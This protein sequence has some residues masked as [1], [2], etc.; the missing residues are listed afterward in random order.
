MTDKPIKVKDEPVEQTEQPTEQP[1]D[2][3]E[4]Y[5]ERVNGKLKVIDNLL[6]NE[7]VEWHFKPKQRHPLLI[8]NAMKKYITTPIIDLS[9]I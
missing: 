8:Q 4:Y 1:I 2:D 9:I 7:K 5:A 6:D 3:N